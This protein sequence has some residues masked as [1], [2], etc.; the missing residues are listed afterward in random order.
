MTAAAKILACVFVTSL[1]SQAAF[2]ED[3][4]A[5]Q[6][7]ERVDCVRRNHPE[8][9]DQ[10]SDLA[11]ERGYSNVAPGWGRFVATCMRGGA[12]NGPSSLQRT[13][14]TCTSYGQACI[15]RNANSPELAAKCQ[16]SQAR[17][18][19]TGTFVGPRGRVFT[20]VAKS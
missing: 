20:G 17:C 8:K 15:S 12:G 2:S 3:C 4:R 10:C 18:M 5:F 16:S 14:K 6:G 9:Y 13:S 1:F 7:G 11:I 19:E